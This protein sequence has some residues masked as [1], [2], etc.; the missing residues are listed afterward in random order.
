[1]KIF[2]FIIVIFIS[3]TVCAKQKF[4]KWT[5]ENGNIHYTSEKPENKNANE[6]KVKTNQPNLS[7]N[8][9]ENDESEEEVF[10]EKSKLEKHNERKKIT[11]KIAQQNKS[12]CQEARQTITKYQQQVRMSRTDKK[13]GEKIY[14][15][16]SKRQE[17]IKNAK[18][19]VKKYCK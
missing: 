13:S 18:K 15:E 2:T 7:K 14:L 6:I 3:T 16:D 11:K 12:Q 17:I 10:I 1:M 8:V 19:A 4:Y 9:E 5:D